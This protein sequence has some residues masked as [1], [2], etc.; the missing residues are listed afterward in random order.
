MNINSSLGGSMPNAGFL[1]TMVRVRQLCRE[2]SIERADELA[3][4]FQDALVKFRA[5]P[6]DV[7]RSPSVVSIALDRFVG[8]AR[9][10]VELSVAPAE[11]SPADI[12][13]VDQSVGT[14][15]QMFVASEQ[16]ISVG[17]MSPASFMPGAEV[18]VQNALSDVRAAT[19]QFRLAAPVETSKHKESDY[20]LE[21]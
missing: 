13:R 20:V 12:A 3:A 18:V 9:S 8:E 7:G 2:R 17:T 16:A 15:N 4:R 11:P 14:L 21:R 19:E 10:A 6:A 1:A 5:S